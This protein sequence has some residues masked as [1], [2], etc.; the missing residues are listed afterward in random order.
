MALIDR[1]SGPNRVEM[2]SLG[3]RTVPR[4]ALYGAATSRGLENFPLAVRTVADEP[5]L[6]QAFG[7]VKKAAALTN[8]ELDV[9]STETG[10]AICQA[11]D[12]LLNGAH[13]EWFPTHMLEG[14]GGTTTNM[15]VNEVIAN[16]ALQILGRM[17][18]DYDSVHPNDHVNKGQSTNDAYPTALKLAA[19]TLSDE[20]IAALGHLAAVLGE[21]ANAFGG[22]LRLGRTCLQDAQPMTLGQAFEGYTTLVARAA[23]R[24]GDVRSNLLTVPLGGTAIWTG[25][26]AAD[27][28]RERVLGHLSEITGRNI[29]APASSFDAM[30]NL[31]DVARLSSE[32]QVAAASLAK[33][34]RDL[35]ILSSGP[36]GGLAEVTL[37]ALQPGSSIMPGKVNPVMPM[38][39]V[40][41]HFAITGNHTCVAMAAEDGL[42]EINHYEPV[43]ASRLFDSLR[44]LAESAMLFADKCI[45]D[46]QA[47]RAQCK[48]HLDN[49]YALASA[50]IPRLGYVAVSRLVKQCSAEDR[51]FVD[52][53]C[54]SGL[55]SR[56]QVEPLLQETVQRFGPKA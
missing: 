25:L 14:S 55:L 40:Q 3:E 28:F 20:A 9:L 36:N 4:G 21:K 43:I 49:S 8:M 48:A 31:D 27:G 30:Q 10:E 22:I 12:E 38:A 54:D 17:P 34:G 5:R 13:R 18:G 35:I 19:L 42:L 15:N 41:T 11:C 23:S 51:R 37:P 53:V 50:L 2:D 44:L 46:L 32:T 39:I 7:A 6:I 47:D 26:G 56:E 16:R 33:I 45:A 29:R 52:L 24:L 1:P